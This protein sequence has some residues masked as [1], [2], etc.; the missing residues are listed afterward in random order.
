M[1]VALVALTAALAGTALAATKVGTKNIKR[2]A[3]TTKKIA[4]GAVTA[5]KLDPASGNQF[6]RVASASAIDPALIGANANGVIASTTIN[7]PRP[8][9]LQI[10]A[11]ADVSSTAPEPAI[12]CQ[13]VVDD[14]PIGPSRRVILNTAAPTYDD[15]NDNCATN[16]TVPIQPGSHTVGLH[17][18]GN[19]GAYIF[20]R[21]LDVLFVA[22]GPNG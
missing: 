15:H 22:F 13:I 17:I 14:N 8:G 9:F 21:T 2:G 19:D 12:A 7:A 11:S 20:G 1:V 16:V 3:V 18:S 4:D 6:V 5:S 10:T